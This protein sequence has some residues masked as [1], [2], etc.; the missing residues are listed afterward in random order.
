[1]PCCP[2]VGPRDALG[3]VVHP[4]K[5]VSVN[6]TVRYHP[7]GRSS[8]PMRG[9]RCRMR[10]VRRRLLRSVRS[11]RFAVRPRRTPRLPNGRPSQPAAAA[12]I[13]HISPAYADLQV[14]PGGQ[15]PRGVS[16]DQVRQRRPS[17]NQDGRV[18]RLHWRG[19]R[20][21]CCSSTSPSIRSTPLRADPSDG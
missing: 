14:E 9:V 13:P 8:I 1:V 19:P 12:L 4:T 10:Q 16:A 18:P 17:A 11:C 5:V 7:A 3:N 6:E 20:S 21:T 2:W 15:G